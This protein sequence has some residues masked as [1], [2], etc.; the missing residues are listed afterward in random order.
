MKEFLEELFNFFGLS[1]ESAILIGL[2]LSL[3]K[4][5]YS[6]FTSTKANQKIVI[7]WL[8]KKPVLE[9]YQNGLEWFCG[10]VVFLVNLIKQP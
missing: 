6:H 5:I 8:E 7:D 1:A 10:L 4:I 3:Y 2:I 9:K